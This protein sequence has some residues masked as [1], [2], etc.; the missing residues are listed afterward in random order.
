MFDRIVSTQNLAGLSDTTFPLSV[1]LSAALNTWN[2]LMLISKAYV[3]GC[4]EKKVG[5]ANL[6]ELMGARLRVC[7]ATTQLLDELIASK[8][9]IDPARAAAIEQ[10]KSI[11]AITV[12]SALTTLNNG[13]DYSVSSRA[14]LTD[15]C[16]ET[17]PAIV[18]HLSTPSQK[19]ALHRLE[20]LAHAS[21]TEKFQPSVVQLRDDVRRAIVV[22]SMAP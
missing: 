8:P 1:R 4:I 7:K 14:R 12:A 3:K 11:M 17:L 6:V 20:T 16:R 13:E 22:V 2:G 9:A 15:Y 21:Q 19:E 18:P 5:S 10:L